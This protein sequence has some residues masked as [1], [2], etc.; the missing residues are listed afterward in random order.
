MLFYGALIISLVSFSE[1]KIRPNN[2]IKVIN[3]ND[4]QKGQFPWQVELMLETTDN[5]RIFCS[6][7]IISHV[8]VLTSASCIQNANSISVSYGSNNSSD[9]TTIE[10]KSHIIYK[11]FNNDTL[12]NDIGLVELKSHIIFDETTQAISLSEDVV[13]DGVNVTIAGWGHSKNDSDKNNNRTEILQY[14]NISTIKNSECA[15]VFG[16]DVVTSTVLCTH[17]SSLVQGPCINDG[18]APLIMNAATDPQHVGIF[19]FM[20]ENGCEKNYPA[21]YTRTASYLDWIKNNTDV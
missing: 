20:G 15:E 14:V 7:A 2:E 8:W 18:G 9:A 13:G 21:A 12:Q 1:A 16:R 10:S 3:G 4:A 5:N 19:S 11:N 6:G 17:N